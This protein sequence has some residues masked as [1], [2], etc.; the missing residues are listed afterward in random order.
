MPSVTSALRECHRLRKHLK[1]LQG[2]IDLGPRVLKNQQAQ[3]ERERQAHVD[4]H[5]AI[6]KLKLKQRED[7]GSLKET[8][9]R[10]AKLAEQLNSAG[11]Q[12][13]YDAKQSEIRQATEKKGALEDTI[14]TTIGELDEK[15]AAIPAVEKRWAD[16]QVEFARLQEEGKVRLERL[17]NEQQLARTQLEEVEATLP[18]DR[19]R[20]YYV[21]QVK[22]HGPDALAAVKDRV[23]QGCRTSLTQQRI[24]DL[25]NG[26]FIVC[27]SCGK[28]LYPAE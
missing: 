8:E 19:V 27:T 16:A 17:K 28:L 3:L 11:N 10:L 2:E 18:E 12:K 6:K 13:E 5:E 14:L 21:A 4:H 26:A 23:C 9:T 15:T 24:L 20:P 22:G 25:Q 1:A 7:E